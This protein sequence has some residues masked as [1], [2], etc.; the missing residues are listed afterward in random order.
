MRG[1]SFIASCSALLWVAL[2]ATVI[3]AAATGDPRRTWLFVVDAS[4][5]RARSALTARYAVHDLIQSGAGGQMVRG[6]QIG[7]WVVHERV[8]TE[9]F[10][11]LIWAPELNEALANH[12]ANY[13]RQTRFERRSNFDRATADALRAATNAGPFVVILISDGATPLRGTPFDRAINPT[14]HQRYREM[15]RAGKPFV[16]TLVAE[17]G[18]FV[19][20][21]VDDALATVHVPVDRAAAALALAAKPDVPTRG[22]QT[23]GL[24]PPGLGASA[25]PAET[26]SVASSARVAQS[27]SPVDAN[28]APIVA[29]S[30]NSA[31]RGL[32]VPASAATLSPPRETQRP[33][34]SL[35]LASSLRFTMESNAPPLA[36]ARPVETVANVGN[37]QLDRSGRFPEASLPP[38]V[39]RD[40]AGVAAEAPAKPEPAG[41]PDLSKPASKPG[42]NSLTAG[43]G[44]ASA[45]IAA[46]T[47]PSSPPPSGADWHRPIPKTT[48][49]LILPTS[50]DGSNWFVIAGSLLLLTAVGL[51]FAI[52]RRRRSRWRPSVITQSLDRPR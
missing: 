42:A 29:A 11:P 4:S 50:A 21:S 6:D 45:P 32:D 14:Y 28:P 15:R 17:R 19:A 34:V 5:A 46:A 9:T 36:P 1:R 20:W 39:S 30:T 25:R 22:A 51:G 23:G 3:A 8:E 16:T 12:A 35:G 47:D 26:N 44:A 38:N 24:A 33:A 7:I 10:A 18:Q 40:R 13:L 41:K 2:F 31:L 48:A 37:P 27:A 49:T 52:R 43:D